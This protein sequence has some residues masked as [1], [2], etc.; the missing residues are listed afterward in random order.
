MHIRRLVTED[1]AAYREI[2]LRMLREHPEAFSADADDFGRKPLTDI[3]AQI[4]RNPSPDSIM[5]GAFLED[6][7]VGTIGT[8]RQPGRKRCHIIDIW[9]MY[10]APET[11]R[12]GIGRAMLERALADIGAMDGLD[13]IHIGVAVSNREAHALYESVGFQAYGREPGGIKVG[14]HLE[15]IVEMSLSL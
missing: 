6:G 5:Y 3:Q 10:V 14:A 13:M 12:Q 11:R 15:D 8:W 2:R 7:L 4:A 1:A 9:G